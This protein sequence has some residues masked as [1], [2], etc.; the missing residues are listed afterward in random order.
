MRFDPIN[1]QSVV[2]TGTIESRPE[3]VG[4]P[5]VG[6]KRQLRDAVAV[7]NGLRQRH[8]EMAILAAH[9]P[10][11]ARRLANAQAQPVAQP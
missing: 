3:H 9:D 11:A 6:N 4:V 10:N 1:R 7:V 2:R 8:P 5:G